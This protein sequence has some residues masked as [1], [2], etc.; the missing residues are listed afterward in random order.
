MK[1]KV[2]GKKDFQP[3]LEATSNLRREQ[4][5]E[6][7][8]M[9]KL[10][11]AKMQIEYLEQQIMMAQQRI[12]DMEKT[13]AKDTNA[14]QMLEFLKKDVK[15]NRDVLFHQLTA[16][17]NEKGKKMQE[18]SQTLSEPSLSH[19]ELEV[20]QSEILF[21]QRE[22]REMENKVSKGN[23]HDDKL[24]IYKQR[25]NLISKKREK[26]NETIKNFEVEF[27]DLE[28]KVREKESVGGTFSKENLKQVLGDIKV[29]NAKFKKY[30]SIMKDIKSERAILSNTD[31]ILQRR[32]EEAREKLHNIEV[33]RN[34]IGLSSKNQ[35]I[36]K[37]SELKH[38]LDKGKEE[39]MEELSKDVVEIT[40]T[41]SEKKKEIEPSI[42]LRKKLNE[43]VAR[44]EKT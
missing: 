36:Q 31:L 43:D 2:V 41:I 26:L 15:R 25:L 19:K 5:E 20:L 38:E 30:S 37:V 13:S 23:P 39:L 21:L 24:S 14:Y 8:L 35:E 7:I 3:L 22:N 27:N 9:E 10:R 16:E 4:E 29:K 28:S 12:F 33:E 32:L 34:M 40:K 44:L 18:L 11:E 17:L 42:Q 6:A 1:S